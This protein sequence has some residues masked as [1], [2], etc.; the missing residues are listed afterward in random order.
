MHIWMTVRG[1]D[2]LESH[3]STGR[4]AR[5]LP[6]RSL[7]GVAS[8]RGR[9]QA[10]FRRVV[11]NPPAALGLASTDAGARELCR[12]CPSQLFL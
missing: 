12:D 10:A 9:T 8:S 3:S 1:D 11:C 5:D 2:V 6:A 7:D 4:G